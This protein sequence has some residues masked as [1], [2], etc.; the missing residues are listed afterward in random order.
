[1]NGL[2]VGFL[3]KQLDTLLDILQSSICNIWCVNLGE[4]DRIT[5]DSWVNFADGLGDTKITHMYAGEERIGKDLKDQMRT[6]IRRNRLKHSMHKD[7]A[8]KEVIDKCLL[9]WW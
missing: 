9:C 1:M 3:D 8:N 7:V 4:L 2:G 6:A 5:S